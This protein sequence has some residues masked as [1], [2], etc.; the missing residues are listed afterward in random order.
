MSAQDPGL[1]VE[2]EWLDA[3]LSEPRM[4]VIDC[5]WYL[6]EAGRDGSA[7]YEA[8][9]IPGAVYLDLSTDLADRDAPV[10][11]TVADAA[12]LAE[13]FSRAGVGNDHF[14]VLYDRL[15]G[16]SAGRV[17]W[18]LRYVGHRA[19]GLLNGGFERWRS[20]GRPVARG[21]E[22]PVPARFWANPQPQWLAD[23]GRVQR[24]LREGEV[25]IV[26]ARS[27]ARFRGEGVEHTKRRGHIP[28]SLNVPHGANLESDPPVFRSLEELRR[29]Y[30]SAGVAFDRPVITTCGSGV[31]AALD[32][33]VLTLL[34]HREV[35][36]YDGSWAEW[37]DADEV[38]IET[39]P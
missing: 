2:P 37:G 39:G 34:G 31:T 14:V 3:H 6:P 30:E 15:G 12:A 13:A 26:D 17:W 19:A 16:Y 18:T 25:A 20:E 27:A 38:P 21:C 9:H 28:G 4:S 5:A 1:L 32:A 24:A 8:A 10:R 29:L 7:E 23:K 35:A 11:N 22:T 36:V 33:F